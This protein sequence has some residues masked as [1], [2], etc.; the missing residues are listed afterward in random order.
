[1]APL[2]F[3]L[4]LNT[5]VAIILKGAAFFIIPVF[6]G[7][8]S[9]FIM[10]KKENNSVLAMTILAAPAIFIFAPLIQF[11]PVGL[12]LKMLVIS[13]VFTVLL[14]G[15]L[16]PIFSAYRLK[17]SLSA[18]CLFL[19]IFFFFNAHS[20]SDFN[21]ERKKPTS[22]VYYSDRDLGKNFWLTYDKKTDEWT[23]KYLGENPD[24]ATQYLEEAAYS[25]YGTNY[26]FA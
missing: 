3:W 7:L 6:F 10:L 22:L 19:A 9:F 25:K 16:W 23:E 20:K 5:A 8:L 12:G 18:M 26:T 4:L 11:F 21:A 14:F 17:N 13:C 15:L 1:V 2:F 24:D